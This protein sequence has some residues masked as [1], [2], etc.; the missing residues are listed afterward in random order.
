MR[1]LFVFSLYRVWSTLMCILNGDIDVHSKL[2]Q[3]LF[4]KIHLRALLGH[5]S[6]HYNRE[7]LFS[8]SEE[9]KN[10]SS[11]GKNKKW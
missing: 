4:L 11:C 10:K 6:F 1:S 9:E 2:S 3:T 7:V 5:S 8:Y